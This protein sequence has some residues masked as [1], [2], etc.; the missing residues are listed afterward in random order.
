MIILYCLVF[1]EQSLLYLSE[2]F[3]CS[4]VIQLLYLISF[5]LT[6][7]E[8]FNF[9]FQ[10]QRYEILS[11]RRYCHVL[12]ADDLYYITRLYSLCQHFL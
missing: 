5:V 6:C 12:F 10:V 2:L 4:C 9:F 7:Q 1:R 8:L 3:K 11:Q